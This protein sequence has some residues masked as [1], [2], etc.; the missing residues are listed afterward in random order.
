MLVNKLRI[1]ITGGVS[2]PSTDIQQQYQRENTKVK[3]DYAVLSFDNVKK[4]IHPTETELKTYYEQHKAEFVNS[5]PEKR[6]VRYIPI[7]LAN[8]AAKQEI[9]QQDLQRYYDE[10]RDEFRVP[11]QVN[12]R[13]ILIKTPPA[14]TDGKVDQKAIDAAKA[15]ADDIDKQLK[16]GADFA[17]LAKKYSDDT[18]SAKNGGSLGWISRGRT[19]PEFEQT[20]FSLP[21]GGTSGV[22]RTSYGFHII[23]VDDKQPAKMKSLDEVKTQIEPIIRQE[24][25]SRT[26]ENLANTVET[27]ARTQSMDKAASDHGFQVV[28]T[29][30][31]S[32]TDALPGIGNSPDFMSAVF[33]ANEKSPPDLATTQQGYA[34]FQVVQIKPPATPTFDE[35]RPR[36]TDEYT[37]RRAQTLLQ[38]KTNELADLAKA[39][40]DLKKAAKELGAT[41]KTSDLVSPKDQVPEIG[42]LS[43]PASVVFTLKPGEISGPV[44]NGRTGVVMMLVSKQEPSP[45]EFTKAKDQIRDSLLSQKRNEVF[46][47]FA[48]NVRQQLEKDGKIRINQEELKVLTTPRGEAGS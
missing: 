9:T 19:V 31:F 40:H 2:V 39:T 15:K 30:F 23:H 29:D 43:G 4:S 41:L 22:V 20:A 7:N 44:D 3:F 36:L 48:S 33:N 11:E 1:L 27:E 37:A 35:L 34:V 24:K 38:E 45:A 42:A 14:G 12:V 21:K 32:R 28:T 5:I 18:A 10:H 47:L 25:V 6:K 16:A 26:A 46:M 13:H 8:L 17:A